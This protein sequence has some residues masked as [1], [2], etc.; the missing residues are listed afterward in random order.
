MELNNTQ[1]QFLDALRTIYLER[2]SQETVPFE[3]IQSIFLLEL[4]NQFSRRE[5]DVETQVRKIIED[6]LDK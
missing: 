6:Y 2:Q 5:G 3:L 4:D 1:S